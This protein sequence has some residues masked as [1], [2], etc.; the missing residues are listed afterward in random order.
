MG[1]YSGVDDDSI[2]AIAM[3]HDKRKKNEHKGRHYHLDS[4]PQ[5]WTGNFPAFF[6]TIAL[7]WSAKLSNCG[8]F[9]WLHSEPCSLCPVGLGRNRYF[10]LQPRK[11]SSTITWVRWSE[12]P[13]STTLPSPLMLPGPYP[14]YVDLLLYP[15]P[16]QMQTVQASAFASSIVVSIPINKA[17]QSPWR[18]QY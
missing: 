14:S 8:R 7:S 18:W 13:S 17:R 16:M 15:S 4:C 5:T 1:N 6:W 9:L 2:A 11:K 12:M 10:L 3:S